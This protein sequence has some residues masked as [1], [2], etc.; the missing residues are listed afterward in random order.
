V[1]APPPGK[2]WIWSQE[3]IDAAM[4]AGRIQFTKS[5]RPRAVR[6]LDEARGN[7]IGSVWTDIP[8]VNSQAAERI[9]WP[10][11][12]PVAL[13][14]RIIAACSRPGD[15]V[16]DFFCGSGTTG[17]AAARLGRRH[18]LCDA[19]PAAVRL[20]RRRLTICQSTNPEVKQARGT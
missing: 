11:Q 13:V 18:L 2:H 19:S 10:T 20:T 4:A 5:G 8:P 6:R 1:L 16:A 7:V 14:E 3:R 15:L 17:V 9:G 12:K